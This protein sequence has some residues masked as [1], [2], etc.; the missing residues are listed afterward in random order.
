[1]SAGLPGIRLKSSFCHNKR[2]SSEWNK[3]NSSILIALPALLL[4]RPG[5]RSSPPS[6]SQQDVPNGVPKDKRP[7]TPK[8]PPPLL[9]LLEA[10]TRPGAGRAVQGGWSGRLQM[11]FQSPRTAGRGRFYARQRS[12]PAA[13]AASTDP[14]RVAR[15][16][17]AARRTSFAQAKTGRQHLFWIESTKIFHQKNK[18]SCMHLGGSSIPPDNPPHS[19]VSRKPLGL[20]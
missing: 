2:N 1:M 8:P 18:K 12:S 20:T 6:N 16:A 11:P 17:R 3:N 13:A 19:G 10:G 5:A 4:Q 7:I 9:C 15:A 14:G